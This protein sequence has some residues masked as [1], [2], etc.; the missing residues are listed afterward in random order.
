RRTR[1]DV[2]DDDELPPRARAAATK[3]TLAD[4]AF[5][6]IVR[7]PPSADSAKVTA[8]MFRPPEVVAGDALKLADDMLARAGIRAARVDRRAQ[9]AAGRAEP[10]ALAAAMI[11]V[12]GCGPGVP[13]PTQLATLM[14]ARLGA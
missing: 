10:D 7:P 5:G 13:L 12:A 14:G 3:Q 6:P 11:H 2:I 8:T 9:P 4:L 1:D